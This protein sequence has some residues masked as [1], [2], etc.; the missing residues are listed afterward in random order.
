MSA[1]ETWNRTGLHD[2]ANHRMIS[3]QC[4]ASQ[5][6]LATSSHTIWGSEHDRRHALKLAPAGPYLM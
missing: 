4:S 3:L 6:L 2:L 1:F 5:T